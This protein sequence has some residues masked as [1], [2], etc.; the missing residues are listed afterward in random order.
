MSKS[1]FLPLLPSL[2]SC[3]TTLRQKGEEYDL[4]VECSSCLTGAKRRE[5][6]VRREGR[7]EDKL[8]DKGEREKKREK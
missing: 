5:R 2:L 3:Q 6:Q 4:G 8:E 7:R 1:L